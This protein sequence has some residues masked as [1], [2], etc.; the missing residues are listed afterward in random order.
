MRY[1]WCLP[2]V[3]VSFLLWAQPRTLPLAPPTLDAPPVPVQGA[4][5]AIDPRIEERLQRARDLLPIEG[6]WVLRLESFDTTGGDIRMVR[7]DYTI[8]LIIAR[9]QEGSLEPITATVIN[10]QSQRLPVGTTV[11]TFQPTADSTLYIA[12]W[13]FPGW[14][15]ARSELKLEGNAVATAEIRDVPRYPLVATV[16][17]VKLRPRPWQRTPAGR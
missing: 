2:V 4:P 14:R 8:Q 9:A 11:A 16:R 13:L 6:V 12:E 1:L 3:S 15:A 7:E 17:M 10:S 5:I